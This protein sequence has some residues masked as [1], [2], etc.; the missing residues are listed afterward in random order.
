LKLLRSIIVWW[1]A[2][3]QLFN[4]SFSIQSS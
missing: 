2:R 3:W 4:V 1:E